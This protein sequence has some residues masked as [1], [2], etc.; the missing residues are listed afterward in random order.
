MLCFEN[1]MCAR[2]YFLKLLLLIQNIIIVGVFLLAKAY[3]L[4]STGDGEGDWELI[5]GTETH[6]DLPQ[7]MSGADQRRD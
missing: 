1:I 6:K 2:K 7:E 4:L 5:Q 3:Q